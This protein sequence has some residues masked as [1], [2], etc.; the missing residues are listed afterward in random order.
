MIIIDDF[1]S[2]KR[3]GM[4]RNHLMTEIDWERREDAPRSEYWMNE[5]GED[6]TYGQGRG[7][8]TYEPHEMTDLVKNLREV[9]RH[10]YLAG[11]FR[12]PSLEGCF[13]NMYR[14][15]RDWLGWHADDDP[16]INHEDPIAIITLGNCSR[17]IDWKVQGSKGME[18]INSA[19][20]HPGSLALMPAGMQ[21]THFH[22]IPKAVDLPEDAWRISLTFRSLIGQQ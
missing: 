17:K 19:V 10:Y 9:I 14:G 12:A 2:T 16:G 7:V 11:G 13:L 6:Y 20:L 4:L 22:R 3:Q 1:I 5:L 21:Q 15:G 18:A 8:R